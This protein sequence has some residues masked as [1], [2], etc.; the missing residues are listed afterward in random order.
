MTAVASVGEEAPQV[1]LTS[2][3]ADRRL[4]PDV[5][6]AAWPTR[7]E[8]AAPASTETSPPQRFKNIRRFI[9]IAKRTR[10]AQKYG[11]WHPQH[12]PKLA[13]VLLTSLAPIDCRS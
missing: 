10:S 5:S 6:M 1:P 4:M 2:R 7:G 3:G 9:R 12:S 11:H 8:R 13:N